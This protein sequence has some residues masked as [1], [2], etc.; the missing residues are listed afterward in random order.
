MLQ[1]IRSIPKSNNQT[2]TT[3]TTTTSPAP[4]NNKKMSTT[5][6]LLIKSSSAFVLLINS[7]ALLTGTRV[8][9]NPKS[10]TFIPKTTSTALAESQIRYLAGMAAALGAIAWWASNDIPNRQVPLAIAGMGPFVGG[11]GRGLAA[12]KHGFGRGRQG[13]KWA[14]LGIPVAVWGVGRGEGVW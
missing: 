9:A 7:L 11:L 8:L 6:T 4:N 2:P 3:T 5:T 14:E 12:W 1:T 10:N 13:A